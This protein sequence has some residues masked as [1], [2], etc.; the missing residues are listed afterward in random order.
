MRAALDRVRDEMGP[1]VLILGNRRTEHGIEIMVA[2]PSEVTEVKEPSTAD[3]AAPSQTREPAFEHAATESVQASGR[4]GSAEVTGAAD[5][6]FERQNLRASRVG[7]APDARDVESPGRGL[8]EAI[9]G[10]D[11]DDSPRLPNIGSARRAEPVRRTPQPDSAALWTQDTLLSGMQNELRALRDLVEQQ[12]SGFA[13]GNYGNAHPERAMLLRHMV[14][15]GVTPALARDVLEH[16]P[17]G[18]ERK[19]AWHRALGVLA[20]RIVEYPEQM[21]DAGG[22]FL[23]CGPSGVGKTATIAKIAARR[24]L[25]GVPIR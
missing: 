10:D 13:W 1:D 11:E 23:V 8:F 17:E 24:P 6:V 3:D 18:L 14:K 22:V 20:H 25:N 12:I 15:L 9:L 2:D 5:R 7:R 21:F 19:T 4:T 16:V